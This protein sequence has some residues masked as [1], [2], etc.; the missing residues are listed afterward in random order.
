VNI[1]DL[2]GVPQSLL[3]WMFWLGEFQ[4]SGLTHRLIQR[5][6]SSMGI[7]GKTATAAK[8]YRLWY[9]TTLQMRV[10]PSE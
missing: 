3:T 2:K 1:S 7:L 10:R 5:G 9:S 6:D 4:L 8:Q